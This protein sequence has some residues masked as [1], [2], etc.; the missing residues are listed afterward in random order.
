MKRLRSYDVVS[1]GGFPYQQPAPKPRQFPSKP[2]IED[3]AR[4]VAAY[5]QGNG[6]ARSSYAE[7]LT[8]VDRFVA[9]VVLKGSPVYTVEANPDANAETALSDSAAGMKPCPTC[10]V[11][12]NL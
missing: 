5:R 7:S 3:Q 10:G 4:A 2:L 9:N 12:L 1:P 6:L 11:P 8:D